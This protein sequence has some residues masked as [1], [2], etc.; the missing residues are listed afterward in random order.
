MILAYDV[1][2]RAVS[3]AWRCADGQCRRRTLAEPK[4]SAALL[5]AL[6]AIVKEA[7]E[8]LAGLGVVTGP[9]SFT[10]IR[11]GLATALGLKAALGVPLFGFDKFTL[12]AG[13]IPDGAELLMP[14]GRA[15][16]LCARFQ[17]GRLAEPP[18]LVELARLEPGP[19]RVCL[20]EV[21]GVEPLA[22]DLASRCL[23]LMID[24]SAEANADLTPMYVRPADARRSAPFLEKLLGQNVDRPGGRD[25]G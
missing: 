17:D 23:A 12:A 2:D 14:S 10:G 16:A 25:A 20:G 9:G 13:S 1:T 6:D 5:P 19:R 4:S 15:Q 3:I 21:P 18:R 22:I 8:P 24:G 11:V 7:G